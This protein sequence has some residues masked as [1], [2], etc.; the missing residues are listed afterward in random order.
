MATPDWVRDFY[1]FQH[2]LLSYD[3]AL[4]EREAERVARVR[5]WMPG[6][7]RLLEIGCGAGQT[8]LA[9]ADAG[10]DVTAV[11]LVP[12]L[13]ALAEDKAASRPPAAPGALRVLK[14]DIYEQSFDAPFD[15]I[16]YFDGFGIG[17]DEDQR[18]L[19]RLMAGW[20]APGGAALV[21][22]YTPWHWAAAAGREMTFGAARRRYEFDAEGVRM[23][24]RWWPEGREEEAREQSLRCYGPAD[25]RLLLEGTGLSLDALEPGGA[26]YPEERRWEPRAPLGEAMSYDARLVAMN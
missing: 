3:A 4:G 8:A 25:L 22:V 24:D 10:L 6:A 14:G 16:A 2:D 21:E 9:L 20:L 15:G 26:W 13:A 1:D 5:A 17:A 12:A 19:L 18:R 23:L 7:T 11:E